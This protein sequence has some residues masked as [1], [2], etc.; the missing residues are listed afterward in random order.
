MIIDE[1]N[2]IE[3]KKTIKTGQWK[4]KTNKQTNRTKQNKKQVSEI[5]IIKKNISIIE[6]LYAS[7]VKKQGKDLK[8]V[9]IRNERKIATNMTEIEIIREYYNSD[10]PTSWT[11]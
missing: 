3:G 9:K 4:N 2:K 8:P 10:M 7:I 11:S 6:K 1:K 5:K